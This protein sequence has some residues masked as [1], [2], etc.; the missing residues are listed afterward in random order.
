MREKT[1]R[2]E[3]VELGVSKLVGTD[4]EKI[5]AAT[6]ELLDNSEAYAAMTNKKNPY[7]DGT[8]SAKIAKAIEDY[9]R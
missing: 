9:L 8:A 7:G 2:N 6:L 4:K 3:G 5:V 1:E